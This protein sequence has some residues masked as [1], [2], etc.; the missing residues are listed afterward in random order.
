MSELVNLNPAETSGDSRRRTK[1]IKRIIVWIFVGVMLAIVPIA[2]GVL[3]HT[4]NS[5]C[6]EELMHRGFLDNLFNA[7]LLTVAFTL[8]CAAAV[9]SLTNA[10]NSIWN[11]LVGIVTLLMTLITIFT[12]VTLKSGFCTYGLD[13][14]IEAVK[15]AFGATLFLSFICEVSAP[16]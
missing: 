5:T 9:D 8:S 6:E 12:Y 14:N 13:F 3:L 15:L 4:N 7:E 2:F 11:H 10:W 1:K 16:E